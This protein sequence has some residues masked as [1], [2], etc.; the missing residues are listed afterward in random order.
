MGE[1]VHAWITE[2]FR[3]IDGRLGGRVDR[4]ESVLG[5]GGDM[6][7]RPGVVHD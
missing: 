5:P 4:Q 7:V 3:V 6:T 1:H 2:R